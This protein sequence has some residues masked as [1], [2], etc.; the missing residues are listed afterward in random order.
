MSTF[1]AKRKPITPEQVQ[2][3]RRRRLAVGFDYDFGDARGVHRIATTEKD[4]EGWAEVTQWATAMILKGTS[5]ETQLIS[6]ETGSTTVTALEWQEV[7]AA[8]STFRQPIWQAS[9][10]LQA[11]D[12]TPQNYADGSHW[13]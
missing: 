5:D 2:A 11:M 7:L 9:F 8:A 6:T 4:M 12:P 3:E 10:V 13:P 1:T